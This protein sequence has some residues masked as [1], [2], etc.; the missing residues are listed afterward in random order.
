MPNFFI[1]EKLKTEVI[2]EFKDSFIKTDDRNVAYVFIGNPLPYAND[3]IV[4]DI[5]HNLVSRKEVWANM[6]GAKKVTPGSVELVID[7]RDWSSNTIYQ[8]FDDT[9]PMANLLSSNTSTTFAPMYT[10][11]TDGN[12]YKCLDNDYGKKSTVMPT[13][14]YTSS[15]GFISTSDGY[16]WKYM[17]N[18]KS[19]NKFLTDEWIP[20]PYVQNEINALDYNLNTS[21]YVDGALNKILVTNP[22]D[23]YAHTT[24]NVSSFARGNTYLDIYGTGTANLANNMSIAGTGLL[25][26]TYITSISNELNRIYLSTPAIDAGGGTGNVINITTRVAIEGDGYGTLTNVVLANGQIQ[27]ID[28]TSAG[29]GYKKADITIY[30]CGSNAAARSILP[31]KYGHG[32]SPAREF[33]SYSMMF[34][35]KIGDLDEN[36]GEIIS[37]STKFRQHGIFHGSHKYGEADEVT[38]ANANTVISQTLDLSV[39]TGSLYTV[40]E[41]VYQGT[42]TNKTFYGYVVSEKDNVVKLTNYYGAVD[43]GSLLIGANSSIQRAVQSVK[44]PDMQPESGDIFYVKNQLPTQRTVGQTEEFKIVV[45]M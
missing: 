5:D 28:I 10:Y 41:Q 9:V 24:L 35:V 3:S 32:Y 14:D 15:N 45:Q 13:G 44:Y 25:T 16:L 39:L 31:T 20:V 37:S 4:P 6:L 2:K 43:Q 40:N 27:S 7:R 8:Q 38:Y 19:T 30:G 22:G 1:S 29:V 21:N 23:G 12:V 36:T 34:V 11:T 26:G 17:Y 18:V 33:N 42:L